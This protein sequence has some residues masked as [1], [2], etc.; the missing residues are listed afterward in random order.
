MRLKITLFVLVLMP[1]IGLAQK[2]NNTPSFANAVVLSEQSKKPILLI[3]KSPASAGSNMPKKVINSEKVIDLINA[4]FV[5]FETDRTDKTVSAVLSRYKISRFPA[6]LFMHN[7]DDI[8][9]S[10]FGHTTNENKYLAMVKK[11]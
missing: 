9:H 2:L 7:G 5:V 8:F 3:V 1:F 11:V 10:D 6:F 4:N